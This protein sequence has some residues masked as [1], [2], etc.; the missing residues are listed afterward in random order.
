MQALDLALDRHLVKVP[1]RQLQ[2]LRQLLDRLAAGQRL[3]GFGQAG[4]PRCGIDGIAEIIALF[5]DHRPMV[6]P[7]ADRQLDAGNRRQVGNALLHLARRLKSILGSIEYSHDLVADRLD[8]RATKSLDSPLHPLDAAIH[9][10][11][12]FGIA[13]F[14]VEP[15]A[16]RNVGKQDGNFPLLTTHSVSPPAFSRRQWLAILSGSGI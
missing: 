7:Q 10:V 13:Q 3:A 16:S 12:C 8:H 15:R 1:G 11:Q 14:L 4:Q 2:K 5:L 9:R 6:E